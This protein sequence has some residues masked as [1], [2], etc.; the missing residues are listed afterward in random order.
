M[1]VTIP[2]EPDQITPAWLSGFLGN[3][4]ATVTDCT[5]TRIG[6]DTGF[7]SQVFR[8][9]LSWSQNDLGLPASLV[10]KLAADA[11]NTHPVERLALK[12]EHEARFYREL[13]ASIGTRVPA[14][15]GVAW[16]REPPAIALLLEDLDDATFGDERAGA[17]RPQFE[18]AVDCLA[19]LH[20]RWWGDPRLDALDWLT[21]YGDLPAQL[22]RLPGRADVFFDRFAE[23]VPP[24]LVAL[25]R[26]L[27]PGDAQRLARLAGPPTTLIHVDAHLDNFA[28]RET[29]DG[30]RAIL[31]DWQGTAR[32]LG[33]VDLALLL[34]ALTPAQRE[35]LETDLLQV[36]LET[37]RR[38]GVAGYPQ[39]RFQADFRL[40]LLRWWIGTVN[41]LGSPQVAGWTGRQAA[42]VRAGIE[43][44]SAAALRHGLGQF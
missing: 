17:S 39:A 21:P 27:G 31:F 37:L 41:G 9:A 7:A 23:I 18:A 24:E 3:A 19:R 6:A 16:E 13:A 14:C 20:A 1:N 34:N 42:L 44:I 43:R 4:S 35:H 28:F 8:V 30:V 36:Y 22:A 32:G 10:V 38:L 29:P 33:V 40:A 11:G 25:T 5:S 2:V 12:Y 26:R 15:F